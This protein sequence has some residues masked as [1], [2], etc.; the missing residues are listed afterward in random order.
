M[1]DQDKDIVQGT[2]RDAVELL[3][4]LKERGDSDPSDID[5]YW[6]CQEDETEVSLSREESETTSGEGS[7]AIEI[8][9]ASTQER[10]RDLSSSE[11]KKDTPIQNEKGDTPLKKERISF[12][13]LLSAGGL[14]PEQIRRPSFLLLEIILFALIGVANRYHSINQIKEIGDLEKRLKD[15]HNMALFKRAAVR[16]S[17]RQQ[18]ILKAIEQEGL[19]LTPAQTPPIVLYRELEPEEKKK[20]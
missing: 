14:N 20:K 9:S 3:R 19:N 13:R 2:E 6:S 16:E 18:Y 7:Q 15:V 12:W 8:S 10:E 4:S 11:E 1:Q 17:D 5:A